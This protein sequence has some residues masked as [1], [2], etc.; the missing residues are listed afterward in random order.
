MDGMTGI[1]EIG[2]SAAAFAIAYQAQAAVLRKTA[3][4]QAGENILRLIEAAA[5]PSGQGANLDVQA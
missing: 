5:L 2:T 1:T 3:V 4:E